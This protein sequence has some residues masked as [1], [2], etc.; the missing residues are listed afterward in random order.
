VTFDKA[1]VVHMGDLVFN[2]MHPYIDK[3]AGASIANWMKV[4]DAVVKDHD[5]E[6]I[7][8]FGH[9]HPSRGVT[10]GS[11]DLLYMRDYL[12]ALLEFV[13]GEMKAGKPRDVIVK[14]TDPLK[15]FPDHG[16]LI[17]RVLSAACDELAG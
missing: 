12:S 10:G 6:T 2:R 4:L 8:I 7:Y 9:S 1:N 3:P 16:P 5:E 14:I 17:E 15:G 11:A 13:R